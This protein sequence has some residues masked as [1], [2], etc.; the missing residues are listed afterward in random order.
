MSTF[1]LF[2]FVFSLFAPAAVAAAL[3]LS[4]RVA[5]WQ[6]PTGRLEFRAARDV[7]PWQIRR[8]VSKL[9]SAVW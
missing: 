6:L 8:Y 2:K 3:L 4:T 1:C 9:V 5:N 7:V